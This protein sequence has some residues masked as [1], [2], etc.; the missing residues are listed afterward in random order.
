MRQVIEQLED[1]GENA[2]CRNIRAGPWALNNEG[3]TR[4]TLR[5]ERDYVVAAFGSGDRMIV[6]ELSDSGVRA[7]AFER[8]DVSQLCAARLRA[9]QSFCHF[10]IVLSQ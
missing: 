7:T 4:I 3:G 9:L 1:I 8:A 10:A 6:R 2:H 5:R